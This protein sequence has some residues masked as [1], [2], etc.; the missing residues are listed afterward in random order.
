MH[1]DEMPGRRQSDA[2]A[3]AWISEDSNNAKYQ[4][5]K[6]VT[7]RFAGAVMR[8]NRQSGKSCAAI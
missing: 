6:P 2:A 4:L 7:V 1:L 5:L 3:S 8:D